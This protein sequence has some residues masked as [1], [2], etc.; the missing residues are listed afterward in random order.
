M[1]RCPTCNRTFTDQNLSFCIEDG[2]PLVNMDASAYDAEATIVSPSPEPSESGSGPVGG[3]GQSAPSDWKGPAYQPP[4]QFPPPL[5]GPKKKVWP[6]VVGFMALLILVLVGLGVAAAILVPNMMKAA[7]DRNENR[8]SPPANRSVNENSNSNSNP[9]GNSN[10]NLNAN[11]NSSQVNENE[12]ANENT[13]SDTPPPADQEV[14]LSDL[15]NIEDEWMV[16]NLNADKKKLA[17]ILADD[18]VGTQADGTMQGKADYLRDIK[19]DPT[20]QHWEYQNLKLSLNG[21]RATLTGLARLER[22]EGDAELVLRFTDKFVWRD[23]RWQA[24]SSEVTPV[25]P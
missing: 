5:G 15:K 9:N 17:K 10:S 23:G 6:W 8:S 20:V 25:R 11:S 21:G 2:T 14:V 4:G 22:S 1:K 16:A 7:Q 13:N 12:N 24:V 19:P 3:Q 18:Y